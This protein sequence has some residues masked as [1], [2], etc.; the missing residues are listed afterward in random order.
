[1]G[2]QLVQP[3]VL[4]GY[5]IYAQ[6]DESSE[7]SSEESSDD[8]SD[9]DTDEAKSAVSNNQNANA[10]SFGNAIAVDGF[11]SAASYD[12]ALHYLVT[13]S[14]LNSA[15]NDGKNQS[16][17][18]SVFRGNH[19]G[20]FEGVVGQAV[21]NASGEIK[22]DAVGYVQGLMKSKKEQENGADHDSDGTQSAGEGS[23]TSNSAQTEEERAAASEARKQLERDLTAMVTEQVFNAVNGN[24]TLAKGETEKL[25]SFNRLA[26]QTWG[27]TGG[28]IGGYTAFA[29]TKGQETFGKLSETAATKYRTYLN[30]AVENFIGNGGLVK[31]AISVEDIDTILKSAHKELINNNKHLFNSEE[32]LS[33]YGLAKKDWGTIT[34]VS[35]GAN[36]S[37]TTS[38][39]S[40]YDVYITLNDQDDYT[41]NSAAYDDL[42]QMPVYDIYRKVKPAEI[43]P[44]TDAMIGVNENIKGSQLYKDYQEM[45]S[46]NAVSNEGYKLLTWTALIPQ[47]VAGADITTIVDGLEAFDKTIVVGGKMTKD[48]EDRTLVAGDFFMTTKKFSPVLVG[49]LTDKTYPTSQLHVGS[50]ATGFTSGDEPINKYVSPRRKGFDWFSN[51]VTHF[52]GEGKGPGATLSDWAKEEEDGAI[53]ASQYMLKTATA[54]PEGWGGTFVSTHAGQ[55]AEVGIDGYG[56]IINGLNGS[57]ILPYWQNG[58]FPD[59]KRNQYAGNMYMSSHM[60]TTK[61]QGETLKGLFDLTLQG[62]STKERN[63]PQRMENIV[64]GNWSSN[65]ELKGVV[66]KVRGGFPGVFTVDTFYNNLTTGVEGLS[67]DETLRAVALLI[68]AYTSDNVKAFNAKYVQAAK[69][70]QKMYLLTGNDTI[71]GLND[72]DQEE[73][74][75]TAASLIQKMGHLMD[76]GL[77]DLVKLTVSKAVAMF[78]NNTI[79]NAGMTEIFYTPNIM[80]EMGD[81]WL[82][83]L[84][85]SVIALVLTVYTLFM[86]FKMW[87]GAATLKQ[88]VIQFFMLT[89][90]LVIPTMIYGPLTNYILNYPT[91]A[92]LNNQL[93]T[94]AILDTYLAK[95][96]AETEINEIYLN[97]F[98]R[99][100]EDLIGQMFTSYN[101]RFYT[102]TDKAG[103]DID[104]V[105]EHDPNL[106]TAQSSRVRQYQVEGLEYPTRHLVSV[107]VSLMDLYKWVWDIRN[108]G[109]SSEFADQYDGFPEYSQAIRDGYTK[110]LFEW[111]A[112][113]GSEYQQ[114]VGY[115]PELATYKEYRVDLVKPLLA[116]DEDFKQTWDKIY[117][118]NNGGL[119]AGI[120]VEETEGQVMESY[121]LTAS[122]L[123]YEVVRN[124]SEGDVPYNLSRLSALSNMVNFTTVAPESTTYIPTGNDIQSLIRDLSLTTTRRREYYGDE[125]Y[126]PFT[127]A[128]MDV[129]NPYILRNSKG[130]ELTL[131]VNPALRIPKQDFLDLYSVVSKLTPNRTS[132]YISPYYKSKNKT[133]HGD[134]YDINHKLLLNYL[135]T[136]SITRAS[137]GDSRNQ[138]GLAHAEQMVMVTEAYFQFNDVLN[139]RHFPSMYFVGGITFDKYLTL[140]YVPFKDY[141]MPT[142]NFYND[143]SVVPRSTAEAIV[144]RSSPLALL[145][146]LVAL[147][148]LIVFGFLY[149]AIFHGILLVVICYSYI[150][151]YVIKQNYDNKSWLGTLMIYGGFGLGKFGLVT[152]WWWMSSSFNAS[153]AKHPELKIPY[154]PVLTHS[155]YIIAYL[156]ILFLTIILP[157]GKAV[158]KDPDNL[159]G[160][161]FSDAIGNLKGKF[162]GLSQGIL[163]GGQDSG[164]SARNAMKNEG[165]KGKPKNSNNL[166]PS[167][168][169]QH[170]QASAGRMNVPLSTLGPQAQASA[171]RAVNSKVAQTGG[172]LSRNQNTYK[173]QVG[174]PDT[175]VT[176]GKG[177]TLNKAESAIMYTNLARLNNIDSTVDGISDKHLLSAEVGEVLA[178]HGESQITTFDM[179]TTSA[180][181]VVTASLINKGINAKSLGNMVYVDSTEFDLSNKGV[182]AELFRST[183]QDLQD[184]YQTKAVTYSDEKI[185]FK[186]NRPD[187]YRVASD[188]K[189]SVFFGEE[190]LDGE[191]YDKLFASKSFKE[192]FIQP[193]ITSSMIDSQG[194]MTG[195]VDIKPKNPR[196]GT[197]IISGHV[198]EVYSDD[199][200][201]RKKGKKDKREV[202]DYTHKFAMD[203]LT[204]ED[205]QK[206]EEIAGQ[207]YLMVQGD[208]VFYKNTRSQKKGIDELNSYFSQKNSDLRD[209]YIGTSKNLA[210]YVVKD[211]VNQG[212]H[213]TTKLASETVEGTDLVYGTQP[214]RRNITKVK[215]DFDK[216]NE[217]LKTYDTLNKVHTLTG[218]NKQDV[219]SYQ[220]TKEQVNRTAFDSLVKRSERG[221]VD[222]TVYA[223]EAE[224]YLDRSVLKSNKAYK[225]IRQARHQLNEAR[226][227]QKISEADYHAKNLEY[228]QNYKE[229]L[230]D[231]GMLDEFSLGVVKAKDSRLHAEY[232]D[233]RKRVAQRAET[234][235]VELSRIRSRDLTSNSKLLGDT[236][237]L[238]VKNGVAT[239]S[240]SEDD[241]NTRIGVDGPSGDT[242]SFILRTNL[243]RS[244]LNRE[245]TL[246]R[247]KVRTN[248]PEQDFVVSEVNKEL[249]NSYKQQIEDAQSVNE[250]LDISRKLREE[251]QELTMRQIKQGVGNTTRDDTFRILTELAQEKRRLYSF[252]HDDDVS[253]VDQFNKAKQETT[254][255]VQLTKSTQGTKTGKQDKQ[256]K[257]V[258]TQSELNS[259]TLLTGQDEFTPQDVKGKS[260]LKGSKE[261]KKED[262]TGKQ[263]PPITKTRT[264]PK[265]K[266]E[267]IVKGITDDEVA[268]LYSEIINAKTLQQLLTI[269]DV[270]KGY[271]EQLRN[272][273]DAQ[274]KK[275]KSALTKLILDISKRKR[276]FT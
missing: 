228:T 75:W 65:R 63:T 42:L 30:I 168:D 229:L 191:N 81:S 119:D 211:G 32:K 251:E 197:D 249:F 182:R 54:D 213:N 202:T 59:L 200:K 13:Y 263:T 270:V 33:F 20:A 43:K 86:A 208:T 267:T 112:T 80:Q 83:V 217:I 218:T 214:L 159:G 262:L 99:K 91:Q 39:G 166:M 276:D 157:I 90:V 21:Q 2:L 70:A 45:V 134:V 175:L 156:V 206:V 15:Y 204:T 84:F 40:S 113:G 203:N 141:M 220:Q 48:G 27:W 5:T 260:T 121:R 151:N 41:N 233:K 36:I 95:D 254:K 169:I 237:A 215:V 265:I 93:K 239:V 221:V 18:S 47:L 37:F 223:Q 77:Y 57:V 17:Y 199:V 178:T 12:P 106:T 71:K 196:I 275:E 255:T 85:A 82:I 193:E 201:L 125:G 9:E 154:D 10:Y 130:E 161:V 16:A 172:K 180:A 120:I 1:M 24:L 226:E 76:Y 116:I 171:V 195:W 109:D 14:I 103:F 64:G 105:S 198:Q 259:Q 256:T 158:L 23:D 143:V 173:A 155:I 129:D 216:Q 210:S 53:T 137:L 35:D 51:V 97:M 62:F 247:D 142:L 246:R 261:P 185:R 56:N 179:G 162:G 38:G 167:K 269:E 131:A 104:N 111:L 96:E 145:F 187:M 123:F 50:T 152:L 87:R 274:A 176:M 60:F 94:T 115:Q 122:E 205:R 222:S 160:Q 140:V 244:Y 69:S 212:V 257:G 22:T 124:S 102:T 190:G 252:N 232:F 189:V 26:S 235:E 227:N 153:I 126:A 149:L 240:Y 117:G 139:L 46:A 25:D 250:V 72:G 110:P 181:R 107:D 147:I 118:D 4:T 238:K 273:N 52:P 264:L 133:I 98:D 128:V 100:E 92:I 34:P 183:V 165:R 114:V 79:Q 49:P 127:R 58:M 224:S 266:G 219:L 271:I 138:D 230:E 55:G 73:F 243:N 67:R 61:T 135:T 207:H 177:T 101:L 236:Q 209:E 194:N 268:M 163:R 6:E 186:N 272:R 148:L 29:K 225:E 146:F 28:L 3:L 8:D 241:A 150:K 242:E 170:L 248:V 66:D 253:V 192:N 184:T 44:F 234:D 7:S 74:R 68:T 11:E 258:P 136:Y 108:R 89:L 88:L 231:A 19:H 174:I 164:G 78:Y 132:D 245:K 188:G 31:K 144:L